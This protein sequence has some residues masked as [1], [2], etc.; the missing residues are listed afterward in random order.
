LE[1]QSFAQK[2]IVFNK[3]K[4]AILTARYLKSKYAPEKLNGKLFLPGGQ[5]DFGEQ[6]DASFIREVREE[7]GI[8]ILPLQPVY[9]WTW[10]YTKG[11][12]TKQIFAVARLARY[13]S[14]KLHTK[15]QVEHEVEISKPFW[16]P[17]GKV[18]VTD[19]VFDEQPVLKNISIYRKFL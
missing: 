6:P 16:L 13:Q 1:I 14:G 9:I 7:S 12:D 11:A 4:T 8:T 19:F 5:A 3:A 18:K 17:I 10:I 2:G 15:K